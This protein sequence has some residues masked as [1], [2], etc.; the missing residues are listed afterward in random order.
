MITANVSSKSFNV[1][2]SRIVID[3]V[4]FRMKFQSLERT[5]KT[6][7]INLRD[8]INLVY[9]SNCLTNIFNA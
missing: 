5:D 7:T 1:L 3:V 6:D 4:P 8:K 9:R 2:Y